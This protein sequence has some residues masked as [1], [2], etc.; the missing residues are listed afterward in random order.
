MKQKSKQ[1]S[2]FKEPETE[3]IMSGRKN[4]PFTFYINPL[5]DEACSTNG[6]YQTLSTQE[7]LIETSKKPKPNSSF[8]L[9]LSKINS[10]NTIKDKNPL[11]SYRPLEKTK[12]NSRVNALPFQRK[13]RSISPLRESLTITNKANHMLF[14]KGSPIVPVDSE[15][16]GDGFSGLDSKERPSTRSDEEEDLEDI[17]ARYLKMLEES[18]KPK[19]TQEEDTDEFDIG[20]IMK[21][22]KINFVFV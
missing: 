18:Y 10:F 4:L 11:K 19:Q 20:D 1:S 16:F 3:R 21:K 14:P 17:K 12:G 22:T 13:A 8:Y 5:E 2:K 6:S 7:S 15:R 9:E